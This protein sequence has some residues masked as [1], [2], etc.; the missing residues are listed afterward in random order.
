MIQAGK[1]NK[2]VA[3]RSCPLLAGPVEQHARFDVL[4]ARRPLLDDLVNAVVAQATDVAASGGDDFLEPFG[5]EDV[6]GLAQRAQRRPLATQLTLNLPQFAGLLDG[7]QGAN[8][9]IEQ[10]QQHEHAV[11]VEVQRAVAGLVTLA[12]DIV[13]TCQQRSELVEILQA[14]YV[15]LPHFLAFFA[16]HARDYAR[17]GK[18]RNTTCVGSVEM[19]K[20]RAEQDWDITDIP[21][22]N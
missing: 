12:A 19:R 4:V 5:L 20:S 10:E 9:R 3:M 14:R 8:H 2:F 13:Q 21:V 15:F 18:E 1:S 11:L 16:G 7:P 17:L 22:D 6:G